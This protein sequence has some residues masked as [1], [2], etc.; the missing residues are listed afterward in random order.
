MS[1]SIGL[2]RLGS[3]L[4]MTVSTSL[5]AS[6]AFDSASDPAYHPGGVPTWTNGSNGGY[7][8]GP[9][10]FQ[11]NIP[12]GGFAGHFIWTSTEN[13]NGVDDGNVNGQASDGDID[14]AIPAGNGAWGLYAG[15]DVSSWSIALRPFSGALASGDVFT[16]DFD[17]GSI[18]NGQAIHLALMSSFFQPAF[19]L[20]FVGGDTFYQ[21][22][23]YF[24]PRY[25]GMDFGDEGFTLSIA[26]ADTT[27]YVMNL[28]R[29]D[30]AVFTTNGTLRYEA[31]SF[32]AYN[33]G[34]AG[35][36]GGAAYNLYINSMSIVPEPGTI[37]LFSSAAVV[38]GWVLWRRRK[39]SG[40]RS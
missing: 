21:I 31:Y 15:G 12:S 1:N 34:A 10:F 39:A 4:I 13:G 9:W 3:V 6:P 18:V 29:R 23:D 36:G 14:T 22:S 32:Q 7:G 33:A 17:N 16:V 27:N 8:F 20:T 30:G 11:T 24:G 35:L 25:I 2:F 19:R 26:M 37:A 38:A 40:Q 5:A 28:T